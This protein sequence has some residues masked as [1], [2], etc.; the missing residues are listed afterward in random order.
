M[1]I[2]LADTQENFICVSSVLASVALQD[3]ANQ[4]NQ[5]PVSNWTWPIKIFIVKH[6]LTMDFLDRRL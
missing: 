3:C 2:V 1:D 6:A 5:M 4:A